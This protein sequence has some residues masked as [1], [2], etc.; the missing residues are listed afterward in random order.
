MDK[1]TE[2]SHINNALKKCGYPNWAF[3]KATKPKTKS[4]STGRATT[5]SKG[6]VVMPYI[7]GTSEAIRR[8]FG[9]YEVK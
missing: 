8:T 5:E 7:K 2:K 9:N 6:Q 1:E 4:P 3:D